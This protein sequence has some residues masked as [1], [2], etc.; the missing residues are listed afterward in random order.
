[1]DH[2]TTDIPP[3]N[4]VFQLG[5]AITTE[6]QRF[7][8]VHG[9]LHFRGVAS[10]EEVEMLR[11]EV[12][13]I[14]ESWTEEGRRE[15]RGVPIFYGR[16]RQGAPLAQRLPFTSVFSESIR[17]LIRDPRFEPVRR[18]IGEDARIGDEER[19]ASWPTAS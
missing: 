8:D 16:D 17:T 1:M 11:G 6:Q 2:T 10:P 18:L 5:D 13:R 12:E 3:L 4:T 15:I 9:F 19:T 14:A 7:L